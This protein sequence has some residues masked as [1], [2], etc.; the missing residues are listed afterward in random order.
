MTAPVLIDSS[1][2]T[3]AIRRSG[4]VAI[5]QRVENLLRDGNAA[6]CEVIR[7]E[8]WKGAGT[9]ADRERIRRLETT[10]INLPLSGAVWDAA[11]AYAQRARAAG[12]PVPTTDLVIFACA[13]VHGARI[14]HVDRHF[15]L[16]DQMST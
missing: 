15:E 14:E 3:H 12:T 9:D 10:L 2:W 6:W 5:R 16:L 11:C 4:N 8:L 13:K 1:A 7:L